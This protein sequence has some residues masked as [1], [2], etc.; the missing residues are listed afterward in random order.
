MRRLVHDGD[1]IALRLGLSAG[2]YYD[3][4]QYASGMLKDVVN[5]AMGNPDLTQDQVEAQSWDTTLKD[6]EVTQIGH[7][8][9]SA[10]SF[11]KAM[12]DSA[13]TWDAEGADVLGSDP[14]AQ[15]LAALT[16]TTG[17]DT[18][19]QQRLLAE[20][21]RLRAMADPQGGQG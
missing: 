9:Y 21:K 14:Q 5:A 17:A 19:E 16:G 2:M 12:L 15:A 3:Q 20:S 10:A 13:A 7:A 8:D 1:E 18:A 4:E 6:N 11:Q